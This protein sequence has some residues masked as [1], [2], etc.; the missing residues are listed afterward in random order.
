M[1]FHV[2]AKAKSLIIAH[3]ISKDNED[4]A[5]ANLSDSNDWLKYI[6]DP[7]NLEWFFF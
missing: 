5:Y 3:D 2:L 1:T 4:N 7:S 6:D